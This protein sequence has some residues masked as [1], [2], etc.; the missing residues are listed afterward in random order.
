MLRQVKQVN[1]RVIID[2]TKAINSGKDGISD[3]VAMKR[4]SEEQLFQINLLKEKIRTD[5]GGY[6]ALAADKIERKIKSGVLQNTIDDN[7]EQLKK[8]EQK[9]DIDIAGRTSRIKAH[10]SKQELLIKEI[11][12]SIEYFTKVHTSKM[13]RLEE[14]IKTVR[15]DYAAKIEKEEGNIVIINDKIDSTIKYFTAALERCYEPSPI[16]I[17]YP[18][19]HFKTLDDI[20]TL[21]SSYKTNLMLTKVVEDA[22]KEAEYERLKANQPLELS[23]EEKMRLKY[24]AEAQAEDKARQIRADNDAMEAEGNANI[25]R[26]A[27]FN[28]EEQKNRQ[29]NNERKVSVLPKT[30]IEEDKVR[31]DYYDGMDSRGYKHTEEFAGSD[32]ESE[33]EA[34]SPLPDPPKPAIEK[35]VIDKFLKSLQHK[36]RGDYQEMTPEEKDIYISQNL[37]G[38]IT[39]L[40]PGIGTYPKPILVE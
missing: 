1:K 9:R 2:N 8:S 29:S 13:E 5:E 6:T 3:V 31:R 15:K 30:T 27:A 25:A 14:D 4:V 12:D 11:R 10:E 35:N 23:Q 34:P 17:A 21:E 16:I 36:D 7:K 28:A 26:K 38:N 20:K 18:A 37:R 40:G 32:A 39:S 24:R 33:A 19:S 22:I